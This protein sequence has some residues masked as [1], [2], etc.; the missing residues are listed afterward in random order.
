MR[1]NWQPVWDLGT[2]LSKII[3]WQ[4]AWLAGHDMREYT[5]NEIKDY[6]QE[7]VGKE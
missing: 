4:K 3:D 2:T 1:L 6:M 5:L 7:R